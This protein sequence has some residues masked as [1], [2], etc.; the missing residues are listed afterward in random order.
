MTIIAWDGH[1]LAADKRCCFGTLIHTVTK[2]YRVRG[3]L[4]AGAGDFDRIQEMVAWF[5]AGADPDKLPPFQRDN[6]DFVGVVVI[7]PDKT[8]LKYERGP[9]P[10]K[11]ESPFYATGS[12]RD[13][14][15]AAMHLGKNAREAVEVAIALD[16]GCGNGVDT[17]TY[18]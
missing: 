13:Y 9:Y 11:I 3:H 17:M 5:A 1:T 10:F 16:S 6:N 2:I 15:M 18:D 14:A 12:G 4:V 7:Q 8:I